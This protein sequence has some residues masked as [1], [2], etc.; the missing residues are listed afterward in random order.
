MVEVNDEVSNSNEVEVKIAVIVVIGPG[1]KLNTGDKYTAC[2][3]E[4]YNDVQ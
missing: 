1:T 4:L 2:V 3:D